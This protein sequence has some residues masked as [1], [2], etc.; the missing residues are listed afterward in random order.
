MF[1][2]L[3]SMPPSRSQTYFFLLNTKFCTSFLSAI[4]TKSINCQQNKSS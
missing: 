1:L 3:L 4:S 2:K